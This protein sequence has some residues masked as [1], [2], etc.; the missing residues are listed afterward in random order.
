MGI[1]GRFHLIV[2]E[3]LE[4]GPAY[5]SWTEPIATWN[6]SI[7]L[8]D[9]SIAAYA[10]ASDNSSALYGFSVTSDASYTYLYSHC[11][12]QFGWDPFGVRRPTAVRAR[13]RLHCERQRRPSAAR[14]LRRRRSSTGTGQRGSPTA[15]AAV[16]VI[17]RENRLVNPTQV[18]FDGHQFVARHEGGRLVGQHHL[19]RRGT[20]GAGTVAHVLDD[21]RPSRVLDLQHLLRIDRA[22]AGNRTGRSFWGSRATRSKAS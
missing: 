20:D 4:R 8:T 17:P 5:L 14:P 10:P 12:R 18:M 3:M 2:A 15:A 9:M 19:P 13:L 22:L 16:P 6:V 7:D 21:R 1:D 11:Y